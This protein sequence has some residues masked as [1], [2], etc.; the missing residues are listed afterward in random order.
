MDE[1]ASIRILIAESQGIY[2]DGLRK[3]LESE[4]GFRVIGEADD[5]TAAVKAACQLKPDILL[6][7]LNHPLHTGLKALRDL[8]FLSAPV[9]TVLLIPS[10]EREQL[11]EAL[12]VGVRGIVLKTSPTQLLIKGIR[13]VVNGEYWLGPEC[14]S[15]VVGALRDLPPPPKSNGEARRK[16]F[17]LTARELEIVGTIVAGCMNKDIAHKFSLSEQ[18]VKHHLTNIFDKVGVSNRLELA[19]FAVKNDLVPKALDHNHSSPPQSV[20]ESRSGAYAPARERKT[21]FLQRVC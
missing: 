13:N 7:N 18:T 11:I 4:P 5:A 19:L 12:Q 14:V 21:R 8:N 1:S 15:D 16:N 3:L 10:I 20:L 9:R 6:L 2:R 17:G